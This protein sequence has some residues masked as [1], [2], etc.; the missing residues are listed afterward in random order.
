MGF[1]DTFCKGFTCDTIQ[2]EFHIGF[3]FG[4]DSNWMLLEIILGFTW[5]PVQKE[6]YLRFN[7]TNKPCFKIM[8]MNFT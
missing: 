8:S 1:K 4:P 3:Y 7:Y 6:L 5:D 2:K